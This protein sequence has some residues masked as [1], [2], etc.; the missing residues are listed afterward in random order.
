MLIIN[1]I[2]PQSIAD[3]IK[4]GYTKVNSLWPISHTVSFT[5]NTG[6]TR[7]GYCRKIS[8]T[9]YLIAINS[10]L[11]H[12]EDILEVVVHE[13]LHSYPELFNQT[14][15][16]GKRNPHGGEWKRRGEIIR[17]T[18]GI[19]VSRTNNFERSQTYKKRETK[20]RFECSCCHHSWDYTKTP[21]WINR[22]SEAKCPYCHTKTIVQT[23]VRKTL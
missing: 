9:S 4:D 11:V 19:N 12:K 17:Q 13:L 2:I 23:P 16:K 18:Y 7:N 3:I 21:K 15:S 1:K 5:F 6:K 14:N 22:I 10:D 8:N 20:Y